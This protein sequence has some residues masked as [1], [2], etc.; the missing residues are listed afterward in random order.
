MEFSK[1]P[2][3]HLSDRHFGLTVE[4]ASN[5]YQ[6]ACVCL[7]RD[8]SSPQEFFLQV[9]NTS[10]EAVIEWDSPDTRCK[11]AWANKDDATRDGAYA[12]AIAAT[13]MYLKLYTVSR[14]Q[15]RTG[16]DYLVSFDPSPPQDLENCYRLEVS[17][18]SLDGHEI[19]RRLHDKVS[20]LINGGRE[21]PAYAVVVGFKVKKVLIKKVSE[22]I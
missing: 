4:I 7:S 11:S 6:A 1:L 17:G 21:F 14:A 2:L 5:Y 19:D 20:Q 22:E 13:E 18:T 9:D 16:A 10:K 3:K 15:T 12:V 8:H